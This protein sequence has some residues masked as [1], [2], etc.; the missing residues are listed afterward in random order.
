MTTEVAGEGGPGS[1]R[2]RQMTAGEGRGEGVARSAR[3]CQPTTAKFATAPVKS[4]VGLATFV[5]SCGG[6]HRP[7]VNGTRA[8]ARGPRFAVGETSTLH[9]SSTCSPFMAIPTCPEES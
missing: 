8:I 6:R 3:P 9:L 1:E 5:S 2:V 7:T 4:P